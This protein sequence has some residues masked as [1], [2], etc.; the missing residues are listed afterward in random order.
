VSRAVERHED[1]LRKLAIRDDAYVESVLACE[2][3][4]SEAS[5]LDRRTRALI[6]LAAMIA[7]DAAPPSYLAAAEA[8]LAC[9]VT[10]DEMVGVLVAVTPTVGLARVVSAA[11]KLALALGYDL[12]LALEALTEGRSGLW[13]GV[14]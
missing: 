11:P 10:K 6:G 9:G 14:D 3:E 5:A 1:I 7:L 8:G 2:V 12:V 13:E 4:R